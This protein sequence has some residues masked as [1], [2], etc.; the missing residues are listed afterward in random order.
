MARRPSGGIPR[1]PSL[2]AP[3]GGPVVA[4]SVASDDRQEHR[5]IVAPAP[6]PSAL[7]PPARNSLDRDQQLKQRLKKAMGNM[8]A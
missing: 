7:V 5:P 8:G 3:K 2:P 6:A 4:P 1:A